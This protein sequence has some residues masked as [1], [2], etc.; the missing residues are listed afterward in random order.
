MKG[1]TIYKMTLE[2]AIEFLA[3][4][5][6]V[7]R[8]AMFG[9]QTFYSEGRVFAIYVD[10]DLY[11]KGDIS[12]VPYYESQ[13]GEPFTYLTEKGPASMRYYRFPSL[14]TL[15]DNIETALQVAHRAPMPKARKPKI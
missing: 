2:Q 8:R 13:G 11:L 4:V 10:N 3:D 12:S 9:G 6:E 15:S 5:P 14:E 7:T 1:K